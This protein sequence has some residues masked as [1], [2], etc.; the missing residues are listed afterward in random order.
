MEEGEEIYF[1]LS[2]LGE[3]GK[4]SNDIILCEN[5][6]MYLFQAPVAE[7]IEGIQYQASCSD[8]CVSIQA[9]PS[10]K[11]LS[12]AL[13]DLSC[14]QFK[15]FFRQLMLKYVASITL[16]FLQNDSL[17]HGQSTRHRLD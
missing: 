2:K 17:V 5:I 12:M 13:W 10:T 7:N 1:E 3:T 16:S 15:F 14:S 4:N 9:K 11:S 6:F 8:V